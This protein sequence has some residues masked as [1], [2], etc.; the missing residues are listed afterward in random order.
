MMSGPLQTTGTN[1]GGLAIPL[2]GANNNIYKVIVGNTFT[3]A[4]STTTMNYNSNSK[5]FTAGQALTV[6][7]G[8][9][10]FAFQRADGY[11][12]LVGLTVY[13]VFAM[14]S[15]PECNLWRRLIDLQYRDRLAL[16]LILL[17][18]MVK[19]AQQHTQAREEE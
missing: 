8:A 1:Y 10:A 16:G 19:V 5:I 12:V 7:V 2:M 14:P 18:P 17:P 13:P 4:A 11:W 9:G 3:G 15:S 6:G